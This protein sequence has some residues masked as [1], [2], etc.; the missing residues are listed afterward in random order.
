[1]DIVGSRNALPGDF[2]DVVGMLEV[3]KFPSNRVVTQTVSIDE[4]PEAI[5]RWSDAPATVTK[6]HVT[7]D[8]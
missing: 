4:A 6:I 8:A 5:Q 3:G 7:L 1:L 2:A